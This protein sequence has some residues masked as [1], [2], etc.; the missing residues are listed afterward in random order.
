MALE[1]EVHEHLLQLHTVCHDFGQAGGKFCL[2]GNR[3]SRCLTEH[4]LNNSV[5]VDQL[6]L[7]RRLPVERTYTV[8][9]LR[10]TLAVR[11]C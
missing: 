11:G 3:V 9:D 10:R 5:D 6:A 8:D 2:H 7:W 4:F 1:H